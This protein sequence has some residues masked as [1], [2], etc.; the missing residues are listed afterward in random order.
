MEK[1]TYPNIANISHM[2]SYSLV[3]NND[4]LPQSTEKLSKQERASYCISHLIESNNLWDNLNILEVWPMPIF[5]KDFPVK[6]QKAPICSVKEKIEWNNYL[7]VWSHSDD[8]EFVQEV[9]WNVDFIPWLIDL[10]Y[11]K[12]WIKM[13]EE[14]YWAKVDIVYWFFV[15]E[16]TV[17]S[18]NTFPLWRRYMLEWTV[19]MMKEW[20]YLV[21]DNWEDPVSLPM[22][23]VYSK[24]LQKVAKYDCWDWAF[25]YIYRKSEW[26]DEEAGNVLKL[27]ESEILLFE[28]EEKRKKVENLLFNYDSELDS[29]INDINNKKTSLVKIRV[30]LSN[31]PETVKKNKPEVVSRMETSIGTLEQDIVTLQTKLEEIPELQNKK[32]WELNELKSQLSEIQSEVDWILSK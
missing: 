9:M 25:I 18:S 16:W 5:W 4:W 3:V 20:W 12:L 7:W 13:V 11:P 32:I 19:K 17:S 21:V 1:T 27:R 10:R 24:H 23:G 8:Q 22:D 31:I 30:N 26:T 2:T 14:H 28:L 6:N 29:K 15:F